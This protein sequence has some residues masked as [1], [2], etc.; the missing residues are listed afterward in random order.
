MA[1]VDGVK[2]VSVNLAS[3]SAQ[4]DIAEGVDFNQLATALEGIG[5]PLRTRTVKLTLTSM[6]CASCVGRVAR[7][8]GALPGVLDVNVNLTSESATVTIA[9]GVVTPQDL[10]TA[11]RGAGYPA[12]LAETGE[13]LSAVARKEEDARPIARRP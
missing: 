5:Y 2:T 4:L 1:N 11:S 12:E 13:G 9:D 8:L 6:S 3:L 7:A 10:L